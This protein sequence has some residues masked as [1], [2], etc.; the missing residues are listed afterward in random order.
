MNWIYY[1]NHPIIYRRDMATGV[2]EQY[3]P[4]TGEWHGDRT[5]WDT[6]QRKLV[7]TGDAQSVDYAEIADKVGHRK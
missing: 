7:V 5:T 3:D 6:L 1:E 2:A 4:N